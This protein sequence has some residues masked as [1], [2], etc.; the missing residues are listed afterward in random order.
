MCIC[1]RFNFK[2]A[3]LIHWQFVWQITHFSPSS[4]PQKIYFNNICK[5]CRDRA[6]E[7]LQCW[8]LWQRAPT[9]ILRP[10]SSS[11]EG[12]PWLECIRRMCIAVWRYYGGT[13]PEGIPKTYSRFR[14]QWQKT[15]NTLWRQPPA[16]LYFLGG[17]QS[18]VPP[19]LCHQFR[20]QN[21]HVTNFKHRTW[22]LLTVQCDRCARN[23]YT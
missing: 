2:R 11:L 5:F 16:K 20:S 10:I 15:P 7:K 6:Q 19:A 8:L 18:L 23:S 14:W 3:K 21:Y 17:S 1:N 12:F 13:R 4:G 22:G 9:E